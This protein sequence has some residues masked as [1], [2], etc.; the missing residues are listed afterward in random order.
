M[1]PTRWALALVATALIPLSF[2]AADEAPP[3]TQPVE[4]S[5]PRD[6][7]TRMTLATFKIF[8]KD[9]TATAFLVRPPGGLDIKDKQLVLV[10]ARHVFERMTGEHAMLVLRKLDADGAFVRQD[11]ELKIRDGSHPLWTQHATSDVAVL[12]VTLPD[13]VIARPIDFTSLAD[14]TALRR[15]MCISAWTCS[16]SAT[17]CAWRRIIPVFPSPDMPRSPVFR[18]GRCNASRHS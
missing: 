1:V 5:Q 9:S 16:C 7:A 2:V 4:Q 11:L 18:F 15:P 8:N 6:Y 17:P 3:A 10:T 12:A 13:D 14:E